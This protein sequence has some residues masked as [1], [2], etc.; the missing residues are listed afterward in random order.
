MAQAPHPRR[1]P[2]RHFCGVPADKDGRLLN[3]I[4]DERT[5]ALYLDWLA[6]YLYRPSPHM[7]ASAVLS[8]E[9]AWSRVSRLETE[10]AVWIWEHPFDDYPPDNYLPRH[11]DVLHRV[12]LSRILSR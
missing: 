8:L 12:E 6:D 11:A 3:V 4:Y 5:Y 7:P 10:I 1:R 2:P 9:D